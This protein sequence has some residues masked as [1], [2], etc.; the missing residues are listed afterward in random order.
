MKQI[1]KKIIP[2]AYHQKIKRWGLRFFYYGN[3]YHCNVCQSHIRKWLPLGYDLPV[4]VEKQI[5]G[6]G[7]REALCPVCGSSD[8]IRLLFH[9]LKTQ[10]EIFDKK[11]KLLHIAPEPSLQF[12]FEHLQNIDYLS[13]DLD[14]DGV[15]MQMDI[16]KIPFPDNHFDAI[17]CN[18]VLEHI[19]DDQKAMS[20]LYR[21]L[22]TAGWAVLQVPFSKILK[23]TFE[24][25]AVTSPQER[26]KVFGQT[27]HVRIYGLDYA[28]RLKTAGFKVSRYQWSEDSSLK[29]LG[30]KMKLN[31]DEPVFFC[32]K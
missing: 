22:N 8:R 4:L 31:A 13:A 5:V 9:F 17:I 20:E 16:T 28:S 24:D 26:E 3:R 2:G 19:P 23:T 29:E 1:I 21:V 6:A 15:M 7:L 14:P 11:L 10:T 18:H 32:S 27:D 12:L 30:K 25:A